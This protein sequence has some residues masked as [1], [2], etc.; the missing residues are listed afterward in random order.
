[1]L[2]SNVGENPKQRKV[3]TLA[4][5]PEAEKQTPEKSKRTMGEDQFVPNDQA[6]YMVWKE[7]GDA[8]KRIYAADEKWL[9]ARHAKILSEEHGV[10]FH[11]LRSWRI[12]KPPT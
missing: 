4:N 2:D 10:R 11:V 7:G 12:S 6:F 5:P 8:P 9:A 3:L 1:M